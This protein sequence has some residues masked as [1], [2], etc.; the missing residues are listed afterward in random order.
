MQKQILTLNNV[1]YLVEFIPAS[2]LTIQH[3]ESFTML[4]NYNLFNDL[5]I[6]KSIYF[7]N[8]SEFKNIVKID[9]N[10][11]IYEES[12]HV[13]PYINENY[14]SFTSSILD[15]VSNSNLQS[16]LYK[17][18]ENSE[19]DI[20]CDYY[21][22]FGNDYKKISLLCDVIRIYK[23]HNRKNLQSIVS[24]SN[25]INDIRFYYFCDLSKN[26][27]INIG[28]ELQYN[29]NTYYEY[30]E[31][32]IPNLDN[33]FELN[34]VWYNEDLNLQY[35]KYF[36]GVEYKNECNQIKGKTQL[37]NLI[38]PY[39][40]EKACSKS[41]LCLQ[42]EEYSDCKLKTIKDTNVKVF[43]ITDPKSKEYINSE[44]NYYLSP[45]IVTL[46]HYDTIDS[47]SNKYLS[48]A[49]ISASSI[50]FS[51]D[52]TFR[53]AA[54]ITFDN[55]PESDNRYSISVISKFIYPTLIADNVQDAYFYFNKIT[56]TDEYWNFENYDDEVFI[57]N[58]KPELLE[59][60]KFNV[61]GYV[62]E[63]SLDHRFDKVF[64]RRC[65]GAKDI[66]DFTF[67]IDGIF[68]DWREYPEII[69]VRTIFI[70]KFLSNAIQSNLMVLTKEKFKYIIN[71]SKK[72]RIDP[73]VMK[74]FAIL[75]KINCTVT[76]HDIGHNVTINGNTNTNV[77]Y[78]TVFYKTQDSQK[79]KLRSTVTQ[80]IG[81]NLGDYLSKVSNF[82][83]MIENYEF[84][85]YGRNDVYVLFRIPGGQ[86]TTTSGYYDILDAD[87]D[88]YITSGTYT[89]S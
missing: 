1:P 61:C 75:D 47:I 85:E 40:I 74:Q 77:V 3:Y 30:I 62:I 46:T 43:E 65:V 73:E 45:L 2:E 19:Q 23:P 81:V 49:G 29:S 22:L 48:Q 26:I 86:L 5:A 60:L 25:L 11:N 55:N 80:N 79:I 9:D 39:Q 38:M 13:Y 36:N 17:E 59:E 52:N 16:L 31:F 69:F 41:N 14:Q 8:E 76:R 58:L 71:D 10:D 24:V 89:V 6:D 33:L 12:D 44:Y 15:Y 82:K 18:L 66:E 42:C 54:E 72:H 27:D 70:D 67:N 51:H 84:T 53:I 78:K 35:T 64:Y 7:I 4:R 88:E 68:L 83:L 50:V 34:K 21:N 28:K 57:N 20:Y 56:N 32:Y 63:M 37:L 87:A